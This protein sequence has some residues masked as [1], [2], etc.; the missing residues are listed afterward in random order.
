MVILKMDEAAAFDALSILYVKEQRLKRDMSQE[1]GAAKGLLTY[2]L[3]YDLYI[4]VTTSEEFEK[5]MNINEKIFDLVD[6]AQ[7]DEVLASAVVE[8]NNLRYQQKR[9]IQD[10]FFGQTLSEVKG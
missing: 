10:R 6:K 8:A 7:R 3:G 1:I 5:L 9:I 2:Q 4:E